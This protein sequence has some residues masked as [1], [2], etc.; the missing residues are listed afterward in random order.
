MFA[1]ILACSRTAQ[2]GKHAKWIWN[3]NYS[4]HTLQPIKAHGATCQATKQKRTH[5]G[6]HRTHIIHVFPASS[7]DFHPLFLFIFFQIYIINIYSYF[8]FIALRICCYKMHFVW[9]TSEFLIPTEAWKTFCLRDKKWI[10]HAFAWY[11]MGFSQVNKA[12]VLLWFFVFLNEIYAFLASSLPIDLLL[13]NNLQLRDDFKC[14]SFAIR[15]VCVCVIAQTI[16]FFFSFSSVDRF[17]NRSY[18]FKCNIKII[19]RGL[20][21]FCVHMTCSISKFEKKLSLCTF[22]RAHNRNVY[23]VQVVKFSS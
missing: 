13:S 15:G 8:F 1:H 9:F 3:K 2:S 4:S 5:L 14:A 20:P 10:H 22:C 18:K 21:I 16:L 19:F 17:S 6:S 7:R 23:T 11:E 12:C